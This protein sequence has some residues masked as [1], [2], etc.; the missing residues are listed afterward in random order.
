MLAGNDNVE[1]MIFDEIDTGISGRAAQ[2]VGLILR[3]T[4]KGKQIICVT[5]LAQIAALADVHLV[6]EKEVLD[7]RTYTNVKTLDFSGRK[8]ELARIMGSGI[9]EKTLASAEEML[10]QTFGMGE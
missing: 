10:R 9:T 6:V 5:H 7:N 1:T 4:A 8:N 3:E 2:K